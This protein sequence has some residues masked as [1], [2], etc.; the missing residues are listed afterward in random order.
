MEFSLLF[1]ALTGTAAGW[2][3]LKVWAE[4][5]PPKAFDM[6][7]GASITGLFTGRVA[8]MLAQGVNPIANLGD[9]IIVRGGVHT[10]FAAVAFVS[11]LMAANRHRLEALDAIAPAALLGLGGWHAGC[12]WRSACL[13]TASDLPWAWAQEGSAIS[14]HPVELYAALLFLL[15]AV[16]VS[17]LG[18]RTWLRF[19]TGLSLAGLIRLVTEPMR[20][21]LSTGPVI[22]YGAAFAVGVLCVVLGPRITA[23][24]RSA[25]I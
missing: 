10:G 15:A 8:A 18:W 1:A 20:A 12:L 13:G 17:R 5:V 19:G 2:L 3:G 4:R 16:V 22:W 21:N 6:L 24:R 25:P 9:L 7:L 14:R 23:T 11:F